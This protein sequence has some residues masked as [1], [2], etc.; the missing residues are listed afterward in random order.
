MRNVKW[1]RY[2][3]LVKDDVIR[4][5]LPE[6]RLF[7]VETV[8]DM[9]QKYEE[10]ILKPIAGTKGNGIFKVALIADDELEI[11]HS[12]NR[13]RMNKE[14]LIEQILVL[15]KNSRYLVQQRI[16]LA[17]VNYCPFDLRVIVQRKK[18]STA[19]VVTGQY[20]K[21]AREGLITTNIAKKGRA[22]TVE[23][24]IENSNM[25]KQNVQNLLQELN[26]LCLRIASLIQNQEPERTLWG[27]DMGIDKT[28]KIWNIEVNAG[29]GLRGF[30]R[31]EDKTMYR[32]IRSYFRYNRKYKP[33]GTSHNP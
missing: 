12:S 8:F 4:N 11:H 29:S 1:E 3:I 18:G 32:R 9:L 22:M 21:V 23:A 30:R 19:W 5:C 10:I 14:K 26:M 27:L 17:E 2:H 24:A 31:L 13:K 25:E 16:R 33:P 20:A 28:G 15:T 6:T 7:D